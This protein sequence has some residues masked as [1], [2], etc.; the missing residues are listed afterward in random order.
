MILDFFREDLLYRF[1]HRRIPRWQLLLIA[2]AKEQALTLGTEIDV[3]ADIPDKRPARI[4]PIKRWRNK[5]MTPTGV[6]RQFACSGHLGGGIRPGT[7]R[8]NQYS[9]LDRLTVACNFELVA[10]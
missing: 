1:V 7:A 4:N 6:K 3:V 10:T 2:C 5:Q 9:C 8:V